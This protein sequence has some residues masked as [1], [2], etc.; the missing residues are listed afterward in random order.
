M[1]TP[2]LERIMV[3][4]RVFGRLG[5]LALSMAGALSAQAAQQAEPATEKA[6]RFE[7]EPYLLFANIEGTAG[8]GRISEAPVDVD[9]ADIL[10]N[11]EFGG[12]LHAEAHNR[13]TGLGLILDYSFMELGADRAGSLGAVLDANLRQ[14]VFE[15]FVSYR[16]ELATGA[17]VDVYGGVRWWDIDLGLSLF[18]GPASRS[19]HVDW[20]DP[21]IG[22]KALSPLGGDW[23]L[24]ARFD[25]GGFGFGSDFTW[26]TAVGAR[27]QINESVAFDIQ[28]RVLSVD[29]AEGRGSSDY[30]AYDTFTHGPMFG[31]AVIF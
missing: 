28:Y 11:L 17:V 22:V 30:F 8:V 15:G 4:P 29:Y 7:I 27:S 23:S 6:W 10:R 24:L 9:F 12:M 31:L 5:L 14:G 16:S 3:H 21:V 20:V 18:P 2:N 26:S 25:V 13:P 1:A 19:R